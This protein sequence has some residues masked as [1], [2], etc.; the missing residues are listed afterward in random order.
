[1]WLLSPKRGAIGYLANSSAGYLRPLKAYGTVLYSYMYDQMVNEPIGDI[2]RSTVTQY[3]D[4]LTAT[5]NRNHARQ[6]NLQG[7]P[8]LRIFYPE[9]PDLEVSENGISFTPENFSAQDDS[10]RINVQLGNYGLVSKDTFAL[11]V[12][13]KLPN[14]ETIRHDTVF[15]PVIQFEDTVSIVLKNKVGNAMTGQNTFEV[16]IDAFETI[17]EYDESNN[18][19]RVVQPVPG[20]IPA[21][22]YPAE[23]A[24]VSEPQQTLK[25][26]AF[27][28]TRETDIP[29]VFE[30]DT[31]YD[32]S[33]PAKV[34]SNTV[35]GNAT[36]VSWDIPFNLDPN[37]VYYWRVR[38]KD[39]SPV[40]WSTS[41]F[42]YI[43]GKQGWAQ[44]EFPQFL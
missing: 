41:S 44:A 12:V 23:F 29:Y 38:L 25:A 15:S 35:L 8:A 6:M 30:I 20:N 3:A 7:D 39:V 42:K 10:F 5:I 36:Y 13:Q 21:I 32:F 33:S 9:L 14:G 17:E 16:F 31:V 34:S 28:M 24:I 11:T 27:F 26:S 40:V 43:P 4:S 18:L 37:T 2:I 22:L 19:A 1:K